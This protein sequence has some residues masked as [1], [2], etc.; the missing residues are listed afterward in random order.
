MTKDKARSGR[1]G[2]MKLRTK[3]MLGFVVLALLTAAS[4]GSG[5]FFVNSIGGTVG[6]FV[7]VTAPLV[8]L[9][10]SLVENNQAVQNNLLGALNSDEIDYETDGRIRSLDG[11]AKQQLAEVRDIAERERVNLALDD[12]ESAQSELV[13]EARRALAAHEAQID[14][15]ATMAGRLVEFDERR[16]EIEQVLGDVARQAEVAMG[17]TEDTSKTLVQSGR[18]TVQKLDVMFQETFNQSYPRVLSSYKAIARVAQLQ[19][20]VR[21]FIAEQ[22]AEALA[23]I[24]K[25]FANV[26]KKAAGQIKRVSSISRSGEDKAAAQKAADGLAGMQAI[27]AGE[28]GLF[29]AHRASLA[30]QAEANTL[31]RALESTG[32]SYDLAL[33]EMAST[34]SALNER[35]SGASKAAVTTATTSIA[36]IVLGG[37]VASIVLGLGIARGISGPLLRLSGAMRKL[38]DGDTGTDVMY[39]DRTNEIGQMAQSVQVFKDNAIEREQL[40]TAQQA[41]RA[42]KEERTRRMEELAAEFDSNVTKALVAAG[43]ATDQMTKTIEGMATTAEQSSE[44]ASAV[45]AASEQASANVNAVASTTEEMTGSVGEIGRQVTQSAEIAQKAVSESERMNADVQGLAD[46]AQKI[47]EVVDLI[48][49][50]A[51]QTNLLALN[52][53]IEAAR[54]GD[55]GKGFAVVAS[56]VKSLADQTAKATEEIA[57]QISEMQGA[58]TSAVTAI[59]QIGDRIKEIAEI[60][61]SIAAAMEEQGAAT[62]EIARNVQEAARGTQEVTSN[63]S[64]VNEATAQTGKSAS[65][66]L[67]AAGELSATSDMLGAEVKKFLTEVKAA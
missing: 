47:G 1:F 49:D 30:A 14:A 25:R 34:A 66:A 4:G 51:S 35:T 12:A 36:L 6:V 15:D 27:A 22:D 61:G 16:R 24:E 20:I 8:K 13:D 59:K 23:K 45:S 5:L 58:T 56:E 11:T 18:A 54:A 52:A 65:E 44:Q 33:E 57:S 9:S 38:A 50:I 42:A 32:R 55:A 7:D 48:N 46:A 10:G 39:A 2:N 29:A 37:V 31:R 53:T 3:L 64:S 41:E 60:S 43:S 40:E 26:V 19:D 28:D 17:Q 21:T 63:I 62:Q 67:L